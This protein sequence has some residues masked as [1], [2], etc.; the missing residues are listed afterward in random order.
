MATA[1]LLGLGLRAAVALAAA[2]LA[3]RPCFGLAAGNALVAAGAAAFFPVGTLFHS[4]LI[5]SKRMM[6]SRAHT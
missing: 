5:M 2:G 3:A 4:T 6:G 1:A